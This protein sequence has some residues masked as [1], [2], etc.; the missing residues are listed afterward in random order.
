MKR[1]ACAIVVAL[2]TLGSNAAAQETRHA[3]SAGDL[4]TARGAL[5]EGLALREKGELPTAIMRLQTAWDLVPTPVTGFEL[6]KAQMM[7]GLILQAHEMF[8][9]VVRMPPSAEES[10]RSKIAREE[11]AR[12]ATEI[13]PR[14]PSLRIRLKLPGGAS[15]QVHVDEELVPTNGA[16][17]LRA[18]DPG[19]HEVV[20]K[21]GDGPEQHVRIEVAEN[22]VKDVELTPQWIAPKTDVKKE[23][24]QIVVVRQTTS[25]LAFVGFAGASAGLALTVS[26][27]YVFTTQSS[28]LADKCGDRYCPQ[29]NLKERNSRDLWLGVSIAGGLA[30]IGF[31]AA[32]II[33]ATNPK[34]E[35]IVV[36]GAHVRP[37]VGLGSLGLEGAF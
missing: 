5:K 1:L 29:S 11:S 35:T 8:Q 23:K 17:T 10:E 34:K 4:A 32:G 28:D 25:L 20:A 12:L 24:G 3:P 15:A 14:I 36:G 18:V 6:G 31:L 21:A 26:S 2:A 9:K 13:E 16:E 7:A 30:T 22:E 33:G 19:T 37:T 27:Y